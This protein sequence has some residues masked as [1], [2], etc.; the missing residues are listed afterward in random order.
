[1]LLKL[2]N[3]LNYNS[4]R[5]Q[6]LFQ[7]VH[8]EFYSYKEHTVDDRVSSYAAA[9]SSFQLLLRFSAVGLFQIYV[10]ASAMLLLLQKEKNER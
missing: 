6:S 8:P 2:F 9:A 4:Q 3:S 1:M 5:F 10:Y 7:P